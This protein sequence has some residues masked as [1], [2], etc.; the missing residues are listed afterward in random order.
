MR[1]VI[2][3]VL[4]GTFFVLASITSVSAQG[5]GAGRVKTAQIAG[6][7]ST[8]AHAS[9]ATMA[10]GP[11]TT[12]AGGPKT[13]ATAGP[14]T[15]TAKGPKTTTAKG[16][17]TTTTRGPKTATASSAKTTTRGPKTTTAG[18][19]KT[20]THGPKTTTERAAQ[21]TTHELK[22]T[23]TRGSKTTTTIGTASQTTLTS[24]TP[25]PATLPKNP[26]LVERL[27]G[28]LP[29]NTDMNLAATGFRNQGQ[30]VAAVHVSNNLGL[31]FADVKTRMVTNG[32][33]LGQAI[34]DLRRNVDS[35]K[36][37]NVAI[38]QAQQDLG[39]ITTTSSRSKQ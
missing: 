9:K 26:R 28:L 10:Q 30:F 20:T 14:K 22:T 25:A 13:T 21:A 15:T 37:A 19:A 31:N 11:K 38:R 7:K 32:M 33:S 34:H 16:P 27:R 5:K 36:A 6:P 4:L 39:V 1:K 24:T 2:A 8:T 17:K 23:T 18:G 29:P 12:T 3:F 35:E